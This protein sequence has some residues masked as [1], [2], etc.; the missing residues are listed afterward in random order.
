MWVSLNGVPPNAWFIMENPIKVDILGVT[1][2]QEPPILIMHISYCGWL[3][4][5]IK[6]QKDGWKPI[7]NGMFTTVFKRCWI[8][9]STVGTKWSSMFDLWHNHFQIHLMI[10]KSQYE[11]GIVD[12]I[13]PSEIWI[14]PLK[15]APNRIYLGAKLS[16]NMFQ[17]SSGFENDFLSWQPEHCSVW[18]PEG[19]LP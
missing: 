11:I 10:I 12:T 6:H 14:S 16:Q 13:E 19:I 8:F 5:P 3:R 7:N 4:K 18:L 2:F 9:P 17:D 1:L 15:T